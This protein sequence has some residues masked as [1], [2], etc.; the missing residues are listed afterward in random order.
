MDSI[1]IEEGITAIQNSTRNMERNID[2]VSII[3]KECNAIKDE[4]AEMERALN[5]T[6]FMNKE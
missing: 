3:R 1:K 2:S 6:E 5:Y 4:I